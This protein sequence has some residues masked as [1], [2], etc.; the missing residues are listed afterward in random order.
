MSHKQEVRET[1]LK[2]YNGNKSCQEIQDVLHLLYPDDYF[3][4]IDVK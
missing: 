2:L 1:I 3:H 4:S